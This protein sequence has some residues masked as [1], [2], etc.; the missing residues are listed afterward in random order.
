[1]KSSEYQDSTPEPDASELLRRYNNKFISP[2]QKAAAEVPT[3]RVLDRRDRNPFKALPCNAPPMRKVLELEEGCPNFGGGVDEPMIPEERKPSWIEPEPMPTTNELPY[4][5]PKSI[6]RIINIAKERD[7]FGAKKYGTRLQP[8]NGRDPLVDA[9]Q[10]GLDQLVY[11]EQE[12]FERQY[13][14]AVIEA[15]VAL[16]ESQDLSLLANLDKAVNELLEVKSQRGK[17]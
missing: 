6:T 17:E 15:A 7:D 5:W 4:M 10:E 3:E 14:N 9:F 2:E 12:L 16:V 11:I 8:F 1:M 13:N